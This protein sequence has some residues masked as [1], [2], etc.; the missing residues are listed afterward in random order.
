[1]SFKT[2]LGLLALLIVIGGAV[3]FMELRPE[4]PIEA[5]KTLVF[6]FRA[7]D[8]DA[9]QVTHEG[10]VTELRRAGELQWRMVRP[11][12]AE[13]DA[14]RVEGTLSR[15]A[16]L[17]ATRVLTG[18]VGGLAAYGLSDPKTKVSLD[19]D[20]S[21]H[22]TLLVGDRTPDGSSVYGKRDGSDTIYILPTGIISDFTKLVTDP[23][24]AAPAPPAP[25]ATPGR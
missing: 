15:L 25:A 4:K 9:V 17:N 6:G 20:G 24:K 16:P 18:G 10:K 3:Y 14:M 7:N 19:T 1:M 5:P 22:H 23:P 11:E 2:T 8:V 12:Q 21:V 13:A